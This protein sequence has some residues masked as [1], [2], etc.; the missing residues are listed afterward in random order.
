MNKFEGTY[1]HPLIVCKHELD[2]SDIE[3]LGK[4]L[5]KELNL[6]IEIDDNL[7]SKKRIYNPIG[8]GNEASLT[9]VKSLLIPEMQYNLHLDEVALFIFTDFIEVKF[10]IPLDYFHLSELNN[11]KEL[12][13]IELLKRFFSQLKAIGINEVHFGIFAE[14]E[15]DEDFTYCWKNICRILSKYEN[16]FKLDI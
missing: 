5:S 10:D 11:R 7:L 9:A 1:Q 6:T 14:F 15:K 4:Q 16:Y 2:L 13:E 3:I 8:I 12:L